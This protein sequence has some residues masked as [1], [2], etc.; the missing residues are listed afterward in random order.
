MVKL[1]AKMMRLKNSLTSTNSALRRKQSAEAARPFILLSCILIND[2]GVS[3][4]NEWPAAMEASSGAERCGLC[5]SAIRKCC[6]S[7]SFARK[8]IYR[9]NWIV[10]A[11]GH[12]LVH[13]A[14]RRGSADIRSWWML[15]FPLFSQ[16]ARIYLPLQ[17][18][19]KGKK[20]ILYARFIGF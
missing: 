5:I 8:V 15:C 10:A 4:T 20:I 14:K 1:Q 2:R 12:C 19:E 9:W 11:A 3:V 13:L 16:S 17:Q 6:A 18:W 7:E